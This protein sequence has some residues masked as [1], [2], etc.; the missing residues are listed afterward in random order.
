M[1]LQI[2]APEI[3]DPA[4]LGISWF[5]YQKD[6]TVAEGCLRLDTSSGLQIGGDGVNFDLVPKR[7]AKLFCER[8]GLGWIHWV[9][10]MFIVIDPPKVETV[11]GED[12]MV[13]NYELLEFG[14]VLVIQVIKGNLFQENLFLFLW[15]WS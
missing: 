10:H 5:P 4:R 7:Y 3:L 1:T 9:D 8:R 11:L 12:V 6:G 15:T 13:V 14:F 2:L